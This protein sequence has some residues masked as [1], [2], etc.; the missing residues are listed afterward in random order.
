M[1]RRRSPKDWKRLVKNIKVVSYNNDNYFFCPFSNKSKF[2]YETEEK[3]KR[4]LYYV[5]KEYKQIH[6]DG[7]V[8]IRYYKCPDPPKGCGKWHLTS[9]S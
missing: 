8:P 3:A 7:K 4:A 5:Q 9:K 2:A 1:L 6:K